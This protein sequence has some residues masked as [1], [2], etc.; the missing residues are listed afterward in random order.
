MSSRQEYAKALF[1]LSE[2]LSV[3]EEVLEDA[4]VCA[5][6]ISENPEYAILADTPA[7]S[8]PEK[9]GLVSEAFNSVCSPV[10][11]LLM[12][13]CEKH[14]VALFPAIAA[15]YSKLYNEARGII[16]AEA[17]TASPL[18]EDDL[19]KLREKIEKIT[20]KTVI[21]KNSIDKSLL[22]GIKLRYSGVQLDGTLKSRLDAIEK[23]L[24]I[25][26][27]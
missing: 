20:G 21:L 23:K 6:I 18:G 3:S 1:M 7:L 9:L 24:K 8:V 19:K 27:V 16:P 26:V 25:T 12:I 15:E 13:L 2:E 4:A 5:R 17:I 11:N 22:G 10:K 14:S